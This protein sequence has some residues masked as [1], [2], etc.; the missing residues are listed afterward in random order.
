MTTTTETMALDHVRP[1]DYLLL[2]ATLMR[3]H[4]GAATPG[5]WKHQCLG[6][7]GCAVRRDSRSIRELTTV[8]K[9]GWKEWKADHADARHVAGMSPV[10]AVAV[11][12]L[13]ES[14]AAD[15]SSYGEDGTNPSEYLDYYAEARAIADAFLTGERYTEAVRL[16][17]EG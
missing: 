8:T 12:S 9:F 15:I 17:E 2:A 11:A 14:V 5:P 6:S 3:Q 7:D 13:L 10:V 4:A 1:A 16:C